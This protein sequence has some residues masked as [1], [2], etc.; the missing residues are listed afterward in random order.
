VDYADC[1]IRM[2]VD[3]GIASQPDLE[4]DLDAFLWRFVGQFSKVKI[5]DPLLKIIQW[6]V[7]PEE[8]FAS[9]NIRGNFFSH[10]EHGPPMSES[11]ER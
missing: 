9:R 2:T 3:R 4:L 11:V 8:T 10:C 7:E 5:Q 1:A 6:T